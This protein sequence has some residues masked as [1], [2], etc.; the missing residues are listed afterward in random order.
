MLNKGV[1]AATNIS[2]DLADFSQ[3]HRRLPRRFAP[4]NDTDMRKLF[5]KTGFVYHQYSPAA[6]QNKQNGE[7]TLWQFR[8]YPCEG[9]ILML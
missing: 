4:R 2:S 7:K 6:V 3:D 1:A 9:A 5:N 8:R